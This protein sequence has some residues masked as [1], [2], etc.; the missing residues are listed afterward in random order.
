LIGL[1]A[2]GGCLPAFDNHTE[3]LTTPDLATPVVDPCTEGS[4]QS[5]SVAPYSMEH[6]RWATSGPVLRFE[7]CNGAPGTFGVS[8]L[9]T[10]STDTVQ[11]P[12][13][14]WDDNSSPYA[15]L[16]GGFHM[17]PTQSTAAIDGQV[18]RTW[19]APRQTIR[20]D[21]RLP[22]GTIHFGSAM[23]G[24]R[25]DI[26]ND[27]VRFN[28]IDSS[29]QDEGTFARHYSFAYGAIEQNDVAIQGVQVSIDSGTCPIS[30]AG[31][32]AVYYAYGFD[33]R[34]NS[35]TPPATLLYPNDPASS[36]SGHFAV[37]CNEP[38]TDCGAPR[39]SP[40]AEV[41]LT[42]AAK[43]TDGTTKNIAINVPRRVCEAVEILVKL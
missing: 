1:F 11:I 36:A 41:P 4:G 15:I 43:L 7:G 3:A 16:E 2:L 34:Y 22:N 30:Q 35:S 10:G 5:R 29:N 42:V 37:V 38:E 13:Q 17:D 14:Y 27:L 19:L 21:K 33:E 20:D 6:H 40:P 24:V 23:G 8:N 12:K 25:S 32:C 28:A 31:C 26:A 9:A 39:P 18:L